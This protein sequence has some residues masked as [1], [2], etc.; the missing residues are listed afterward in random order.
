[1]GLPSTK[2]QNLI[3]IAMEVDIENVDFRPR[4][5]CIMTKRRRVAA[6]VHTSLTRVLFHW[7]DPLTSRRMA[8]RDATL[9]CLDPDYAP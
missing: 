6:T 9:I 2:L 4:L 7:W 1:M 3:V 8:D 5:R